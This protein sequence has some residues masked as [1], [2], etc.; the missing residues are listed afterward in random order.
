MGFYH[1]EDLCE[2]SR[3]SCY[4]EWEDL[5][6]VMLVSHLKMEKPAVGWMNI[7]MK[8]S[9]LYVKSCEVG[10]LGKEGMPT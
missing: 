2:H 3:G 6:F 4:A 7:L 1:S 10:S 5:K 9:V 8:V